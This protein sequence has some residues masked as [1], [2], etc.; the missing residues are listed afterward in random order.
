MTSGWRRPRLVLLAGMALALSAAGAGASDRAARAKGVSFA[1]LFDTHTRFKP[2]RTV[3]LRFRA[4][5]KGVPVAL[6][7]ISFSLRHRTGDAAVPLPARELKRGVF[8]V[9]FS[10]AGPGQYAVAA[11]IRG[12]PADSI[13]PVRLGVVGVSDGLVEE[14]PEADVDVTQRKRARGRSR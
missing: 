8:V 1:P 5:D 9:P 4:T 13:P 12:T 7:D 11:A 10:P 3:N 2:K 14:P 6:A